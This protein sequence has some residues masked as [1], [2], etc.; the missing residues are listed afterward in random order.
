MRIQRQIVAASVLGGALAVSCFQDPIIGPGISDQEVQSETAL[1]TAKNNVPG[2]GVTDVAVMSFNDY[3]NTLL[4][5][6]L[7]YV[8]S[9]A[10]TVREVRK[11]SSLMGFATGFPSPA[12]VGWAYGGKIHFSGWTIWADPSNV[13]DP[14][15]ASR[16]YL[17]QLGA[18]DS[19]FLAE[20]GGADTISEPSGHV[21][22]AVDGFCV[23]RS[24]DG[25]TTF[26]PQCVAVPYA[27]PLQ[28]TCTANSDCPNSGFKCEEGWCRTRLL[29][30]TAVGVDDEGRVWVAVEDFFA[31]HPDPSE[32]NL[33]SVRLFVVNLALNQGGGT[34]KRWRCR[35]EKLRLGWVSGSLE[36]SRISLETSGW[37]PF[38]CLIPPLRRNFAY[39]NSGK[40]S[41]GLS[42]S[43]L[44]R[45]VT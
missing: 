33:G 44:S 38:T 21:L 23:A 17:A 36:S 10:N 29:D 40:A 16:V 14:L 5:G 9:N 37:S 43:T 4:S 11:G 22:A 31:Q 41:S 25:G 15:N 34:S 20:S 28:E 42:S 35:P 13:T 26:S 2:I 6:Q 3:T 8:F 12:G 45:V 19:S 7:E 18:S 24:E 1:T 30:K 27:N 39:W 32:P